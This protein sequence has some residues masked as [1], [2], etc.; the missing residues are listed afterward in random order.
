MAN[1]GRFYKRAF[2]RDLGFRS[3]VGFKYLAHRMEFN[4]AAG[5]GSSC[6]RY[7]NPI[8]PSDA[9][10]VD[11]NTG[12]ATYNFTHPMFI[13]PGAFIRLEWRLTDDEQFG[14]WH[15]FY[16]V[17]G[18]DWYENTSEPPSNFFPFVTPSLEIIW[19]I[20]PVPTCIPQRLAFNRWSWIDGPPQ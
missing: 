3:A 2:E 8:T 6:I 14:K 4:G 18:V 16:G 5:L 7:R 12:V 19:H 17:S 20:S 10:A 11:Y 13:T 1:I 15:A 9:V